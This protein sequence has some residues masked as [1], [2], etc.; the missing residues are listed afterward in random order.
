LKKRKNQFYPDD[1]E[2]VMKFIQ[3]EMIIEDNGVGI[4]KE[5]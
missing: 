4:S 3:V 5:G 1:A 2:D